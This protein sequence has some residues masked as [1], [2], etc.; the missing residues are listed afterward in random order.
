[1]NPL[2][3]KVPQQGFDRLAFQ[4]FGN[5]GLE[6]SWIPKL[7]GVNYFD[8]I[9]NHNTKRSLKHLHDGLNLLSLSIL[10]IDLIIIDPLTTNVDYHPFVC[11]NL[12]N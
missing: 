7:V 11:N 4:R 2:Y 10:S 9:S 3:I 6:S 8:E 1:M 12:S 5:M